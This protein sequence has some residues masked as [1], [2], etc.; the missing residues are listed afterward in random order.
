MLH[1]VE[2]KLPASRAVLLDFLC[3]RLAALCSQER[4]D[5]HEGLQSLSSPIQP[6]FSNHRDGNSGL[7]LPFVKMEG[8][9]ES[10]DPSLAPVGEGRER[11]SWLFRF[12]DCTS[13]CRI[14]PGDES[15]SVPNRAANG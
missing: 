9:G 11:G 4:G 8:G 12:L 6:G 2:D 1:L 13:C 10:A 14:C 15:D 7:A 5:T 3:P